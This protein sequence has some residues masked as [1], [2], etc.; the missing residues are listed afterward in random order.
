MQHRIS[1]FEIGVFA[2]TRAI[3]GVGVGLLLSTRI[4]RARRVRLGGILASAGALSTIP[5]V[6][7]AIQR[8]RALAAAS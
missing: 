1:T 4:R 3:L 2:V 8:R 7:R 5:F 6:L